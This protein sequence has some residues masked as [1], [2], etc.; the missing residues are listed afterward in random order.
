VAVV[1]Q[2]KRAELWLLALLV[3]SLPV[4]VA[5]RHVVRRLARER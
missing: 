4:L 2:V 1:G 3:V 5:F